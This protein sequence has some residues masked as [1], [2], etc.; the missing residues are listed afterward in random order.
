MRF[1][2]IGAMLVTTAGQL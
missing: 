2:F 1:C